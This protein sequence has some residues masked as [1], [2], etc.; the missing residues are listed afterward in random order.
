MTIVEG[1]DVHL[2]LCPWIAPVGNLLQDSPLAL[3]NS[4]EAQY[5]RLAA[6]R[7]QFGKYCS[8]C[9]HVPGP[10]GFIVDGARPSPVQLSPARIGMLKL[11]YDR[12]CRLACG[13]CRN[14]PTFS[15]QNTVSRVQEAVISSKILEKTD[16][17]Y[18]TGAGDPFDSPALSSL[19]HRLPKIVDSNQLPK[20]I[21]HT[22]GLTFREK[23]Q[24]HER[25][26]DRVKE[27][28]VSFDD[29]LA[30]RMTMYSED[31]MV[32]R[33]GSWNCL[34]DNLLFIGGLRPQVALRLYYVVQANNFTGMSRALEV[35]KRTHAVAIEFLAL[36]NW[37]TYSEVDYANRAVHQPLHP[38]HEDLLK[39]LE[40][41]RQADSTKMVS[42]TVFSI[43]GAPR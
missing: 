42:G 32:N 31:V 1:G 29:S 41:V 19:L 23:W 38:K 16:C 4:S 9:P 6:L 13:T 37:G 36:E 10:R 40:D 7:G 20:I 17:L 8:R 34:M 30:W 14:K 39:T 3:W 12:T 25:I 43:E 21:L 11:D 22:H 24:E 33:G 18:L 2:C 28:R 27:V 26:R 5:Q 35:T 15:D